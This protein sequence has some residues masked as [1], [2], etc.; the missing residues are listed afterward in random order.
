MN[1]VVLDLVV[2]LVAVVGGRC[3]CVWARSFCHSQ[4][5]FCW[6]SLPIIWIWTRSL[7]LKVTTLFLVYLT[8]LPTHDTTTL[9]AIDPQMPVHSVFVYLHMQCTHT[10][11]AGTAFTG[12]VH[13]YRV[14]DGSIHKVQPSEQTDFKLLHDL[15]GCHIRLASSLC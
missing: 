14:V 3:G 10:Y 9:S 2:L 1:E 5:C 15:I 4:T 13:C 6:M 11:T 8:L 12:Q 7:G